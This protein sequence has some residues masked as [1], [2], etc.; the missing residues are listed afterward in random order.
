M[1]AKIKTGREKKYWQ[2]ER[3]VIAMLMNLLKHFELI[4]HHN[5]F[6]TTLK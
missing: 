6:Q 1:S 5:C 3:F 2:S 4:R